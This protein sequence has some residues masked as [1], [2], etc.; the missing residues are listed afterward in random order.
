MWVDLSQFMVPKWGYKCGNGP[1]MQ[2]L[3]VTTIGSHTGNQA[4]DEVCHRLVDVF[5]WSASRIVCK[6]D[7]QLIN[8]LSFSWSLWYFSSMALQTWVQI[9]RA[10]GRTV[11]LYPVLRDACRVSWL[12]GRWSLDCLRSCQCWWLWAS[13]VKV[14]FQ[15]CIP[16]SV[17]SFQRQ[18]AT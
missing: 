5:F 6:A 3:E 14:H 11:R 10:W 4:F 8:V 18:P 1:L 15:A 9:W 12:D 17:Q 13:V 16:I 2:I 7:F